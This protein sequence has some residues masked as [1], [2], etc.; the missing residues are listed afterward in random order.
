M[1]LS[2]YQR[3]N[4][5]DASKL[6]EVARTFTGFLF[7]GPRAPRWTESLAL[8]SNLPTRGNEAKAKLAHRV[9]TGVHEW[10]TADEREYQGIKHAD[11]TI[12]VKRFAN[13]I[14]LDMDERS[15]EH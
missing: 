4:Q 2:G 8:Y 7:D 1:S 12:E 5:V 3:F 14:E 13:A 6:D 9:G 10:K 15:E 11:T